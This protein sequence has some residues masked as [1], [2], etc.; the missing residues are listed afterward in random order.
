MIKSLGEVVPLRNP[1][2]ILLIHLVIIAE[3]RSNTSKISANR[4]SSRIA[5]TVQVRFKR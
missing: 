3:A 2:M 1:K 5:T 4:T